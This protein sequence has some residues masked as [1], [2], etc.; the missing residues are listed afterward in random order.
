[1]IIARIVKNRVGTRIVG[2][3]GSNLNGVMALVL[4][5]VVA[6][7]LG[8]LALAGHVP[9]GPAVVF[10]LAFLLPLTIVVLLMAHKDRRKA[11]PLDRFIREAVGASA[12]SKGADPIPVTVA[13]KMPAIRISPDLTLDANG[14]THMSP[15]SQEMIRDA[16]DE[17]RANGFVIIYAASEEYIQTAAD[18]DGFVLEI[19]KGGPDSHFEAVRTDPASKRSLIYRRTFTFEE[20][21]AALLAYGS[22]TPMPGIVDWKPVSI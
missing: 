8:G 10:G 20:T 2:R 12:R 22:G 7:M 4:M 16:L 5:L 21:L 15:I 17:A 11:E 9:D 14:K 19:R 13:P 3:A 1:M 18:G 6:V